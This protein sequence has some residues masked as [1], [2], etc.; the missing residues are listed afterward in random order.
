MKKKKRNENNVCKHHQTKKGVYLSECLFLNTQSDSGY[1]GRTLIVSRFEWLRFWTLKSQY[2]TRI[3][4]QI[5]VTPHK[6]SAFMWFD[7]LPMY[8]GLLHTY[9]HTHLHWTPQIQ[10]R[11]GGFSKFHPSRGTDF[12]SHRGSAFSSVEPPTGAKFLPTTTPPRNRSITCL[13]TRWV[14]RYR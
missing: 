1:W 5:L 3:W 6:L 11:L 7:G 13:K 8:S 9:N 4:V 2:P 10:Y 14:K 12:F